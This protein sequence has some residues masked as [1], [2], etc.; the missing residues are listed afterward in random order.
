MIIIPRNDI[1]LVLGAHVFKEV[2]VTCIF[3]LVINRIVGIAGTSINEHVS[4]FYLVMIDICHWIY[5]LFHGPLFLLFEICFWVLVLWTNNAAFRCVKTQ[6]NIFYYYF[7]F[8][9]ISNVIFT[10]SHHTNIL[11]IEFL[12]FVKEQTCIL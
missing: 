10:T 7:F 12:K 5:N 9:A 11:F 1:H 2:S 8:F 3:V 4:S 6:K